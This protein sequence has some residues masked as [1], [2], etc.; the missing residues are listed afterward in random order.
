MAGGSRG[1]E[2]GDGRRATRRPQEAAA[3][4]WAALCLPQRGSGV[5]KSAVV[6]SKQRWGAEGDRWVLGWVH[7]GGEEP[8]GVLTWS[9]KPSLPLPLRP[10]PQLVC[11][12][13]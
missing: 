3:A 8:P 6:P 10:W 13:L 1:R 9:P 12:V 4:A 5:L 2:G 7:L 11:G